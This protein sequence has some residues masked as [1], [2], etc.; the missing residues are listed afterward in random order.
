MGVQAKKLYGLK[1]FVGR[2]ISSKQ[3]KFWHPKMAE[4][5]IVVDKVTDPRKKLTTMVGILKGNLKIERG[6]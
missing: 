1:T 6:G 4:D 5:R 3:K 2:R